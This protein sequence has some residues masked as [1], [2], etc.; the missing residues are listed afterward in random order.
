MLETIINTSIYYPYDSNDTFIYRNSENI[1]YKYKKNG[2]IGK[3]EKLSYG[4]RGFFR[5]FSML[6]CVCGRAVLTVCFRSVCLFHSCLSVF[7]L[8]VSGLS[9]VFRFRVV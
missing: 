7:G 5:L 8:S 3:P 9:V 1:I 2:G 4:H 6:L